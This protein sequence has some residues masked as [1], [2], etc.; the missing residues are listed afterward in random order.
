MRNLSCAV[1]V[2]RRGRSESS[3]DAAGG[4]ETIVGLRPSSLSA[5][6]AARVLL[7][8]IWGITI[9][10]LTYALKGKLPAALCLILVGTEGFAGRATGFASERARDF[11][12]F[13]G[14]AYPALDCEQMPRPDATAVR[15]VDG[16]GGTGA[17]PPEIRQD[18]GPFDDAALSEAV[19][20]F[21]AGAF[22]PRDA[23]R[24]AEDRGLAGARRSVDRGAGEAREGG[25][26]LER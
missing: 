21:R 15:V 6:P 5:P 22:D 11:D 8:L 25:D 19:G 1:Y 12:G 2:R 7:S 9:G 18:A 24:S 14:A 20:F 23:A 16:A 13:G 10:C 3:G 4:A 26:L 17:D